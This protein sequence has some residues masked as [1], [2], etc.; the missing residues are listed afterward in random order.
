LLFTHQMA[1]NLR[2]R[3]ICEELLSD[4]EEDIEEQA[5][6]EIGRGDESDSSYSGSSEESSSGD[7]IEMEDVSLNERLLQSAAR[8]RP[9]SKLKGKNGFTWDT[10]VPARTSDR[11]SPPIVP[12]PKGNAL[13]ANSVEELWS[14]LFTQDMIDII[15]TNTNLKIEEEC[16]NLVA[17]NKEESYHRHTDELEIRAYLGVLYYAG[18]WKSAN[19]NDHRLWDKTNGIS[20][21]RCVF[22]RQ[23]FGFLSSCIRFDDKHSRDANDRFAPVRDV[24]SIF[25]ENCK[26]NYEPS[27]LCTVDEQLLD[28][29]G[30]CLFRVYMKD[31]PDK[32]GLKLISLNDAETSYMIYALPYLGKTTPIELLPDEKVPEY[33]FRKVSE[34][35]YNTNRAVTADNWY[36]SVPLLQRMFKEPYNIK[37]TGTIK[38]NKREIPAEFKVAPKERPSYKFD[39]AS[40]I[41]LLSYAPKKK[42]STKI[43]L[44]VSSYMH[45][46]EITDTKPN[47]VRYYNK[48]KG[49][50]DT[51][52][53]LCHSYTV[54]GRSHRWPQRIFCGILDQAI[55]NARI[56]LTC[57]NRINNVPGKITAIDCLDKVYKFLITPYLQQRYEIVSLRKDI[58]LGIAGILKLDRY[59]MAP[60]ERVEF[61]TKRRCEVCNPKKDRKTKS[62]CASCKRAVCHEH[63]VVMCNDCCDIR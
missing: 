56:L 42:K 53:R 31:K 38:K 1:Y 55:V 20:L 30:R 60:V 11:F 33:F 44:L 51:F 61:D 9:C 17:Q 10:R 43:V 32:Y 4:V 41:T 35:I 27:H 63:S 5:S 47:L 59:D 3:S 15:V 6:E 14:C 46:R 36:T 62:G 52:D 57:K 25:I 48:T 22:S 13:N 19:V 45:T 12:G 24:W 23:R 7:D 18:L 26:N 39:H 28:F 21:Y 40:N 50:T 2:S 58:K 8:G 29:R 37:I 54:S 16:V 49:G 34:P